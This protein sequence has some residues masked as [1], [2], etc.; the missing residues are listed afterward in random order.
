MTNKPE[1]ATI[2]VGIFDV[3]C[4]GCGGENVSRGKSFPPAMTVYWLEDERGENWLC[5][6]CDRMFTMA[7]AVAE[8][9]R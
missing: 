8:L 6:C 4:P 7:E 1:L 5:D 9:M 2:T 3:K